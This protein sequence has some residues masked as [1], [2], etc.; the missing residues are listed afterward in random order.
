MA[1]IY[2]ALV[3]TPGVFASMIRRFLK[4]RY[5]HVVISMDSGLAEAYSFGRRNP[6]VP[7]FAGFEREDPEKILC[8][9]PDAGYL[10]CEM[11][12]NE[13]QKQAICSR[14]RE[15]YNRRWHYHYAV[16][17]LPFIVCGFPFYQRNHYTCSSYLARILSD[18]GIWISEKHFSLVTP[19]DFCLYPHKKVVFEGSL[20]EF[21][22]GRREADGMVAEGVEDRV[23]PDGEKGS[24]FGRVRKQGGGFGLSRGLAFGK[25]AQ[26]RMVEAYGRSV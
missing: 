17:G 23:M 7:F 9:F 1:Q 3:D 4:Q 10:V 22:A 15:D 25:N 13:E 20:K 6:F 19:K 18:H 11:E 26:E 2:L 24:R 14:L 12:C 8:A 21:L 16:L 5:I